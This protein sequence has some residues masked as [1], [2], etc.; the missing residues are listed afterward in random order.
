[1]NYSKNIYFETD[2]NAI[3]S[4]FYYVMLDE[5]A[6]IM[7]ENKDVTFSVFGYTDNTDSEN[8]NLELFT[9]RAN[10]ARTYLVEKEVK[11]DRISSKGFRKMNPRY[12]NDSDQGKQMNRRVEIK[13]VGHY[14]S[15][16]TLKVGE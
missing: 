6:E 14:K 4:G 2:S 10:E 8:H 3:Q 13:S 5:V 15:K 1:M 7:L 12:S 16:T 9:R 11:A